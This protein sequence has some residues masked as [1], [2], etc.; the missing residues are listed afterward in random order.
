MRSHPENFLPPLPE[1]SMSKVIVVVPKKKL[2]NSEKKQEQ[3][4]R[5]HSIHFCPFD[6]TYTIIVNA[7]EKKTNVIKI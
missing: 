7:H 3:E 5:I 6:V 1:K 4:E 2:I